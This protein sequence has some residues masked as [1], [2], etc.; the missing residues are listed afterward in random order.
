MS[1]YSMLI[2]GTLVAGARRQ[3]VINPATEQPFADAPCANTEQIADAVAAA[4]RAFPQWS[5]LPV[6]QRGS[7]LAAMATRIPT[8]A[9]SALLALPQPAAG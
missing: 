5:S 1:E 9:R 3:P 2:D 7:V 4:K 8:F 6:A